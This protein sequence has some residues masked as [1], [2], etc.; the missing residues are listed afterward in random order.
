MKSRVVVHLLFVA[1]V[2]FFS[3]AA[4]AQVSA[5]D[6]QLNGTVHDPTGSV[7]VKAAVSLRSV[8]TNHVYTTTSNSTGFYILT[9]VPPGN[10]EL[11]VTA[12]GFAKQSQKGIVL[13]V[14]QVATLDVGMKVA[15][16]RALNWFTE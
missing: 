3:M 12:A 11:T 9:S 16:A 1:C 14:G 7:I 13:R 4:V 8:D 2:L 5:G 10:Y 6:A 15:G